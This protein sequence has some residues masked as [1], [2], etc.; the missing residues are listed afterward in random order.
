MEVLSMAGDALLSAAFGRLLQK[1]DDRL[2]SNDLQEEVQAELE[3]WKL[4]FPQICAVL[5]DA[6]EKQ[7][8]NDSVKQWLHYLRDLAYDM[9]D[10]LDGFQADVQTSTV[11]AKPHQGCTSKFTL[12]CFPRFKHNDFVFDSDT[13]SKVKVIA[14]RLQS[15][16][17]Q[18]R[19]LCLMSSTMQVGE[20]LDRAA[21]GWVPTTPQLESHVYGRRGDKEDILQKLL[22]GEG[23]SEGYCVLP[24]VG[25]GGIGKTTLARQV[26][27]AVKQED[28]QLKAWVCVSDQFEVM[29]ITKNILIELTKGGCDLQ[30]L[31]LNLL[32]E[33]VKEQ[34][35]N[36][37]FLLVLDDV[38]NEECNLWDIL[39]VPF[40]SGAPG[41]IIIVTTRNEHVAEIM[42]GKDSIYH[43]K[44][45]DDDK[46]LSILA[47]DALGVENFDALPGLKDVG[48]EMV[49]MCKGLPL[50]AKI[51]GGLLRGKRDPREWKYILKNKMWNLQGDKSSILPALMLSYHHLPSHL[52]QCFS[53]CALFP[54]DHRFDK[55]ELIFLWMSG[56][57]L[58]KHPGEEN[59]IEDIGHQYFSE[60]LSRAFFQDPSNDESRYVMHDLIHDLAQYIAGETCCNLE[61][62]LEAKKEVNFEKVRHFSFDCKWLDISKRFEI[63]NK[64]KDLRTFI[65]INS[66]SSRNYLSNTV[67]HD[68]LVKLTRLRALSLQSYKIRKL[69]DSIGD[70]KCLRYLNLSETAIET[71]PESIGF[72]LSLQTLLLRN[73]YEFSKFPATIGNLNG[74]HSLDITDTPSLKD[75]PREIANLKNL[76]ILPKFI[77][78][79]TNG[80]RLSDVKNLL[81]LR[82]YLSVLNLQNVSN[83]QDAREANLDMIEGLNELV[84]GWTFDFDDSRKGSDI[85][86]EV[87]NALRPHQNLKKL[88]ISCYGGEQLSSWIGDQFFCNLSYLRLSGCRNSTSLPSVGKLPTLKEL[89]IED[90]NAIETVESEFYGRGAFTSLQMLKFHN[91]L[92][93]E[94]W[95]FLTNTRV[96]FSCLKDLEIANCPKLTGKLP[97][98]LS[99][100]INLVIKGCPE[101]TCSSLSL[102]SLE[103]LCIAGCQQV[104]LE[105]M[106]NLTSLTMLEVSDILGLGC[107]PKR[108]TDSLTAL[109]D[110]KIEGCQELTYLWEEGADT[111]NLAHLERMSIE[112]CPLLVSMSRE[113]RGLM[114]PNVKYL[115]LYNCGAL[116]C[117]PDGM[118]M[119]ADGSNNM[120]RLEELRIVNCPGLERFPRGRLPAT[121][122]LLEIGDCAKVESLPEGILV[123]EDGDTSNNIENLDVGALPSLNFTPSDNRLPAALKNFVIGNCPRLESISAGMLQHCT[124]LEGMN[125]WD[126]VNLKSLFVNGLSNLTRLYIGGCDA[127]ESF[128]E[129]PEL[130][131]SIPNIKFFTIS[132]C[133]NLK[134]LPNKMDNLTSLRELYIYWCPS[135]KSIPEGGLPP[136]LT[137]LS[138]D[139]ENLKQPMRDW[140]LHT[141]TSLNQFTIAHICPPRN[142][143]PS[144]L[145]ILWIKDVQNLKSIPRGLLQNLNSLTQ[146]WIWRCPKLRSLPRKGLPPLLERLLISGC[147][148]LKG[149]R[150]QEKGDYWPLIA[151][152]PRVE[153]NDIQVNPQ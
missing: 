64:M 61:N 31:N 146:L 93:W 145:T 70:W 142:V 108:F 106:V 2:K 67:V 143:L 87:L 72:L 20:K 132:N 118:M 73:C 117:L 129:I 50:A 127:L 138:I 62:I 8:T 54:K 4:V 35:S 12:K 115:S 114:P 144:S 104:L 102:P 19:T 124:G 149:E 9:E 88:T 134:S 45:L 109:E 74:L 113:E 66:S 25:M 133:Q 65:P 84:L 125:I 1:L 101:L 141:L 111:T 148:R 34:L 103:K 24:I 55:E 136:S 75:M 60:L 107:L 28:F 3:E 83:I 112:K 37:K 39:K 100:L 33:K 97:S 32:Q 85:V 130:S 131:L 29:S 120:V 153:I 23:G 86:A 140:G 96:E 90:M 40:K 38:W 30:N 137:D 69:P 121:C 26:Y 99:S 13:I 42:G 5:K 6:E 79:K 116:K 77:V 128:Q 89:I 27:G 135:I 78:G 57:L 122:Q 18:S 151:H 76:L 21:T 110:I 92:N 139:C 94:K 71:L 80:L 51:L 119:R 126:C 82:G 36:K 81:N 91:M 11:M 16:I 147:P 47:Q 105:S 14:K 49:K 7:I 48:Q 152:I 95:A 43:L 52:K 63:L 41:S 44:V 46:C 123:Q 53:Y 68:W 15:M 10:V 150:F 59:Q 22:N 17:E 98:H 58:Q 56:G